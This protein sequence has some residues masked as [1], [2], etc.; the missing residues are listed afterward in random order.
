MQQFQGQGHIHHLLID[1]TRHPGREEYHGGAHHLP[2]ALEDMIQ[3][4]LQQL[5]VGLQRVGKLLTEGLQLCLYG[6]L[7]LV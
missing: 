1:T 3:G 2:C 4:Q 6:C 7:Y 5:V